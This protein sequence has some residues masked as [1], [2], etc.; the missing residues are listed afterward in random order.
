M[1]LQIEVPRERIVAFCER[2][3]IEKLEF[4]GSVLRDDFG[5]GSDIDVLVDIRSGTKHDISGILDM[6]KE[7]GDILGRNVDLVF[8][9]DVKRSRNY[10]R[11]EAVLKSAE[12]FYLAD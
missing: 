4:F 11:R 5:P 10:I 9:P 6:E 7:L 2:Y 12:V 1:S 8:R 3:N